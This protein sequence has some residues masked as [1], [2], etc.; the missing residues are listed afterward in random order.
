MIPD[1][2][3]KGMKYLLN[4]PRGWRLSL[5]LIPYSTFLRRNY[6]L[7]NHQGFYN[8]LCV[9]NKCISTSKEPRKSLLN[10]RI[11]LSSNK[12]QQLK[13]NNLLIT[14][15]KITLFSIFYVLSQKIWE[16]WTLLYPIKLLIFLCSNDKDLVIKIC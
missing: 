7:A 2:K 10:I 9:D 8:T 4:I 16:I 6:V 15:L 5:I 14:F 11:I 13:N 12:I 3:E 1:I